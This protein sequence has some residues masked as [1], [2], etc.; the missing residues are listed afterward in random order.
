MT[1]RIKIALLAFLK[2]IG[3]FALARRLSRRGVRVLCYHGVW[4]GQDRFPGDSLF[5]RSATFEAHL[6]L[7]I[8]LGYPVIPLAE[9]VEIL[10]GTR[11]GRDGAV[12]ITIDDGW[13]STWHGMLPALKERGLPATLYVDTRNLTSGV[14]VPHVMARY[15]KRLVAAGLAGHPV[16][17][18]QTDAADRAWAE[19]TQYAQPPAERIAAAMTLARLHGVAPGPYRTGRV[20]DYMTP[21]ELAAAAADGLDVQLHSHSHDLADFMPG[22]VEA[23]IAENRRQLAEILDRPP[24]D[25]A[26]FCYPSGQYDRTV[27]PVLSRLGVR[28]STTLEHRIAYPGLDVQFI[29]RL[30]DGEQ[31]SMWELEAD[32]AGVGD[33]VRGFRDWLGRLRA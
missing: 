31:V 6:D 10:A 30:L 7:I 16:P 13:Y 25:F 32:L 2:L 21:A 5:M 8:R 4:L 18:G 20:F 28:G 33:L 29:P 1:K 12:V 22:R 14:P 11:A 3:L 23:E 24:A 15:L 27:G 9:A 17:P 19:V 26:Y